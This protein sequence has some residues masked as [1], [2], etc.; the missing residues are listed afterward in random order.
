MSSVGPPVSV[1]MVWCYLSEE[2]NV[3]VSSF[4][5]TAASKL[6]SR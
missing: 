6:V 3:I 4:W 5:A 1:G 2:S